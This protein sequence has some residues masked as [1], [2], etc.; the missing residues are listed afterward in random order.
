ME[1]LAESE[2]G[3]KVGGAY[4]LGIN[5]GRGD[6]KESSAWDE[7]RRVVFSIGLVGFYL[8]PNRSCATF[9]TLASEFS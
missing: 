9:V 8:R 6:E 1:A 7:G 2:E 4:L 5:D 3:Y